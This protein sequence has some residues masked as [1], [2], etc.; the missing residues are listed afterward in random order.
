MRH[1]LLTL[2][3]LTLCATSGMAQ[4]NLRE[5]IVITLSGDTLHGSID[6]RTDRMNAEKCYFIQDGHN[7]PITLAPVDIQGYRFVDNGRYYVSKK[8]QDEET[9]R[10]T[11]LFLEYVVRG[12][13]S[14]YRLGNS[15]DEGI[16]F[17]EN[18][19]GKLARFHTTKSS[20]SGHERRER[21]SEA[22][23]ITSQSEST[24]QMLWKSGN[25]RSN[26]VKS[27]FNYNQEVCPDGNCELFE[28]RAKKTPKKERF[29]FP[30]IAIGLDQ[31]YL[32]NHTKKGTES[33]SIPT[34]AFT[35]GTDIHFTRFSKGLFG[36]ISATYRH[37]HFKDNSFFTSSYIHGI[38]KH[39]RQSWRDWTF[40]AGLGYQ[41]KKHRIQPQIYGGFLASFF[42]MK[43]TYRKEHDHSRLEHQGLFVGSGIVL[44]MRHN[45]LLFNCEFN[46]ANGFDLK[47]QHLSFSL[48]Y[49]FGYGTKR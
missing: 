35:L 8:I 1:L 27:I 36:R 23:A 28:Y 24:Q 19:E 6:Y 38:S 18:E 43:A 30:T 39:F 17:L 33:F 7:D 45:A 29:I 2:L 9:K 34:A 5:G 42:T 10:D 46:H 14:L 40:K 12:Q 20:E 41:W 44:P 15:K 32:T 13:L 3:L 4:I 48:G 16:Y 37:F 49:Q 26:I 47:A 22:L 25:N 31:Y 11:T 21:L